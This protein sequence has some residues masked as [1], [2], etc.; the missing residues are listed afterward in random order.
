MLQQQHNGSEVAKASMTFGAKYSKVWSTG[1]RFVI[2]PS[3]TCVSVIVKSFLANTWHKEKPQKHLFVCSCFS[4][5]HLEHQGSFI[6]SKPLIN[7]NMQPTNCE[8]IKNHRLWSQLNRVCSCS[9]FPVV[10]LQWVRNKTFPPQPSLLIFFF[11]SYSQFFHWVA[12][13][14][15]R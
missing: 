4:V 8:I 13:P 2:W 7:L 3:Q 5:T 10:R 12:V 6:L 1:S 11:F 9:S 15:C 14:G